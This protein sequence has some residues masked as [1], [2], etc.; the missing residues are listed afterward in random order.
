MKKY[1]RITAMVLATTFITGTF[2]SYDVGYAAKKGKLSF[3]KSVKTLS[4]GDSYTFRVSDEK[5]KVEDIIIWSS[6]NPKIAKVNKKGKVTAIKKGTVII[7]AK[8]EKSGKSVK[9]KLK[10]TKKVEKPIEKEQEDIENKIMMRILFITLEI[11]GKKR[12]K[13]LIKSK[14]WK[15]I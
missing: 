14:K 6:S 10:V 2:L 13:N 4:V 9:Q 11:K 8:I 5:K 7:M 3:S 12:K 1:Y 15:M